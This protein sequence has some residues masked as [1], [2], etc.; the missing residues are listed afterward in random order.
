V[1][2]RSSQISLIPYRYNRRHPQP[3]VWLPSGREGPCWKLHRK[4]KQNYVLRSGTSPHVEF[5]VSKK[6]KKIWLILSEALTT[7]L[8]SSS[9]PETL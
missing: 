2:E 9:F 1:A 5:R 4:A 6:R 8:V 7:K 3:R